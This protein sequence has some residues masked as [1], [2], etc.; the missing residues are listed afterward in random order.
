MNH[1]NG[2]KPK[3]KCKERLLVPNSV[4]DSCQ[5]L[6]IAADKKCEKAITQFFKNTRLIALLC[7]HNCI[8]FL[9]NMITTGER[10]Y[11]AFALLRKLF[12]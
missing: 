6:F 10:Q 9:I 11:Y 3:N 8:L 2:G 1:A 5:D 4:L 7:R 12:N